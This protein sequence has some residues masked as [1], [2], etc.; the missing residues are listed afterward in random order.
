MEQD[1]VQYLSPEQAKNIDPSLIDSV[2]MNSGTIIKVKDGSRA[3]EFQ[4]EI[5]DD[6]N[7]CPKCGGYRIQQGMTQNYQNVFRAGKNAGDE[8]TEQIN[9]EVEVEAQQ[10][11][12]GNEQEVL[13]GPDGKP[14]L[15][16]LLT[17]G[18]VYIG[19]PQYPE[20]EYQPEGEGEIPQGQENYDDQYGL[21][22]QYVQ[23]E[24]EDQNPNAN[25]YYDPNY[26]GEQGDVNYD[27]NYEETIP[28]PEGGYINNQ[29]VSEQNVEQIPY[30]NIPQ[31]YAPDDNNYQNQ[32]E[33]IP[34][35]QYQPYA[36]SKPEENNVPNVE[37]L[38]KPIEQTPI[39]PS[40]PQINPPSQPFK[41]PTQPKE[42]TNKPIQPPV[43]PNVQPG[44]KNV[45]PLPQKGN[46]VPAK[47]SVQPP[48]GK[49]VPPAQQKRVTPVQPPKGKIVP[50]GQQRKITP[51]QPP[52]I[53]PP[54]QQ[55]KITP[56][57]PPKIVPPGQ[58]K[59]IVPPQPPKP[60][61]PPSQQNKLVP[62]K[63]Q[64]FPRGPQNKNIPII[65]IPKPVA[66]VKAFRSRPKNETEQVLCPDCSKE[67]VSLCPDCARENV[68]LCPDC[69]RENASLCPDC[70]KEEVSKTYQPNADRNNLRAKP[71]KKEKFSSKTYQNQ[72]KDY[73]EDN[74]KYH[75]I[76]VT[77]ENNKKSF[78]CV[79]KQDVIISTNIPDDE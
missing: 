9:A 39:Q 32:E 7:I 73:N 27:N 29:G 52:K 48:K 16:D 31:D 62:Q 13:R 40:K 75:E 49:I 2:T 54:G 4:E 34:Q 10:Q 66:P 56:A 57:Q 20:G 15:N 77:T 28:S 63:P 51:A 79:K 25:E 6:Q 61:M 30:E 43:K 78:F 41:P 53:V 14:L 44:R 59:K 50:P 65:P 72:N 19:E 33:V 22:G 46:V 70:A 68:S 11:A 74:Y 64:V 69:A 37:P 55:R 60:A 47:P 8:N 26:V 71:E 67:N 76:N 17:G 3:C 23:E 1:N 58:Q 38:E 18:E 24:Y 35:E 12:E 21:D 42:P 5:C 45:A 36:P